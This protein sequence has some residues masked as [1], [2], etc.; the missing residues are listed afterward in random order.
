M[1]EEDPQ[2]TD[3]PQR[4]EWLDRLA[5][6]SPCG[7]G[8]EWA[9]NYASAEAAW[10]ACSNGLWMIWYL[11]RA[12]SFGPDKETSARRMLLCAL[13][14]CRHFRDRWPPEHQTGVQHAA[15]DLEVWAMTGSRYDRAKEAE[16]ILFRIASTDCRYLPIS[17]AASLINRDFGTYWSNLLADGRRNSYPEA[18]AQIAAV[19]RRHY[20][21]PPRLPGVEEYYESAN[22]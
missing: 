1:T 16:V 12:F 8:R 11:S 5:E 4:A 18:I 2:I 10:A 9:S 7:A 20:A 22:V 14:C 3:W 17:H 6:H 13:D 21:F 19:V 15:A